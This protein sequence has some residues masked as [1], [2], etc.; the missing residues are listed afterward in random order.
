VSAPPVSTISNL[1]LT[2][3]CHGCGAKRFLY[4]VVKRA[5]LC[6]DCWARAGRPVVD[7]LPNARKQ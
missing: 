5:R 7:N 2:D 1:L 4:A 6:S 3:R